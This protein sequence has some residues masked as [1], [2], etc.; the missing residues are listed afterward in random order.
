M[1]QQLLAG[2]TRSLQP[3]HKAVVLKGGVSRPGRCFGGAVCIPRVHVGA[4]GIQSTHNGCGCRDM[5]Q[6]EVQ[7]GWAAHENTEQLLCSWTSAQRCYA[8]HS[9]SVQLITVTCSFCSK[10]AIQ[11]W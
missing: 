10:S 6:Q 8:E 9:A 1:M 3:I 11:A 5:V 7:A 4:C 2:T